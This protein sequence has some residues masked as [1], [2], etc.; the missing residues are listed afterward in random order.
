MTPV[1]EGMQSISS[2]AIISDLVRTSKLS[3]SFVFGP[4]RGGT[5]AAERWLFETFGFDCNLNQPGL[6]ARDEQGGRER[7]EAT[8]EAVLDKYKEAAAAQKVTGRTVR[9]IVKET[10]NV[11]LPNS[12]VRTLPLLVPT[13]AEVGKYFELTLALGHFFVDWASNPS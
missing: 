11:V 9:M 6:M 4:P 2:H 1:Y 10:S 12:E 13:P 3:L 8:W 5:T 7:V